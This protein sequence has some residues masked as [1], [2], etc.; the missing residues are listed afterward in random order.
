M[1]IAAVIVDV[2]AKQTDREFDYKIPDKWLG[3]IQPGMRVIVPFGPRMVQGFVTGLKDK[4]EF[5]KL[6]QIKEPMDLE[7]VLN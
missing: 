6:R 3:L 7:P 5:D 4:S 2:P 1:N